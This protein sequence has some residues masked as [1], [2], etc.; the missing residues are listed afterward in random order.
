M[1]ATPDSKAVSELTLKV[2]ALLEKTISMEKVLQAILQEAQNY[3][4]ESS[5]ESEGSQQSDESGD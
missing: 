3:S 2:D 1:S 4:E 5:E